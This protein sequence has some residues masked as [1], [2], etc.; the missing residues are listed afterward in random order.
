[1]KKFL[2]IS[3][4]ISLSLSGCFEEYPVT[5]MG[6]VKSIEFN[7]TIS[8]VRWRRD[9]KYKVHFTPLREKDEITDFPTHDYILYTNEKHNIGDTLRV[10]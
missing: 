7:D 5:D 8:S 9:Y 2:I 3:F 4:I 6:V 10:E 1:M